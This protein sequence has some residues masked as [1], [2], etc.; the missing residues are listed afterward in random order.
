MP[1]I[2][3]FDPLDESM[4]GQDADRQLVVAEVL[5]V[6]RKYGRATTR[7]SSEGTRSPAG[8]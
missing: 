3:S 6:Y 2:P 1:G 7:R 5:K 4:S 8:R